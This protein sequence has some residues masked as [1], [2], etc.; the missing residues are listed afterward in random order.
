METTTER[1]RSSLPDLN[2]ESL[3]ALKSKIEVEIPNLIHQP[4]STRSKN[5]QG[6]N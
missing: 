6:K 5:L 3:S 2:E 4:L 1:M